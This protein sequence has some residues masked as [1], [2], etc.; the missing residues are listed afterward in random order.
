MDGIQGAMNPGLDHMYR[1]V[2]PECRKE[3]ICHIVAGINIGLPSWIV[4]VDQLDVLEKTTVVFA[5]LWP[6][7]TER[8]DI[9]HL[10]KIHNYD[11]G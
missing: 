1:W 2:R 5:C 9:Y 4:L 7:N 6:V 10:F 8:K 3:T 11:L